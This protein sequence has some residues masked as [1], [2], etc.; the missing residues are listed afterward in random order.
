[1]NGPESP[2]TIT[3]S[4]EAA[5]RRSTSVR[6]RTRSRDWFPPDSSSSS[7]TSHSSDYVWT[8]PERA[9][10]G[11]FAANPSSARRGLTG[12][13]IRGGAVR[14]GTR[15]VGVTHPVMSAT[16]VPDHRRGH[17]QAPRRR[18]E[19]LRHG[20]PDA[21]DRR[22]PQHGAEREGDTYSTV[23]PG[24]PHRECDHQC[25]E[26][27]NPPTRQFERDRMT[28]PERRKRRHYQGSRR[29]MRGTGRRNPGDGCRAGGS[30]EG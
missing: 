26:Y 10:R 8:V 19:G 22:K 3:S 12:G 18:S 21:E 13:R 9:S 2:I 30:S 11:D 24:S 29:T 25:D 27:R 7:T 28:E 23:A 5:T 16:A 14:Y 20:L 17:R 1:M 15:A 6:V 4:A